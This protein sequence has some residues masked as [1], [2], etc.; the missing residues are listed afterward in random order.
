MKKFLSVIL[1]AIMLFTMAVPSFA[2]SEKIVNV[3]LVGYGSHLIDENGNTVW[4]AKSFLPAMEEMLDDLLKDLAKGM[5]IGDFDPYAQRLYDIIAPA[6]ED[7]KLDNNGE[8][9][10]ANGNEY[11]AYAHHIESGFRFKNPSDVIYHTNVKFSG[12]IYYFDY[13]WRLSPEYNGKLLEKHILNVKK[14]TGATKVNLIGRCLGGNIISALLQNASDKY[15]SDNINKVVMYIPSTMGVE[16]LTALMSGKIVLDPDAID[17]FVKYSMMENDVIGDALDPQLAETLSMIVEFVNEAYILGIGTE[18]IEGIVE[19]VK[20]SALARIMR[21]TYG[22]FPSFWSM[23]D[24]AEVEGAIN[25]VYNT[26]ELKTQYA[27][28]I[29]KIRSYNE[30]VQDNAFDRMKALSEAGL[31]ISVVSKYNYANFPLS[32]DAKK[33]SDGTAST[34]K[35]SFGATTSN[36]GETLTKKYINSLSEENLKYLSPDKM[37][38]ASTALFPQKTWF[39][40][41]L[42]HGDFPQG[43]DNFINEILVYNGEM[44]IDTY[45]AYPQYLDYDYET[46]SLSPVTG[47]DDGDIIPTG[48]EK[49]IPAFIKFF[50]FMFNLIKKLL[51]GELQLGGMLG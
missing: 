9:T 8:C 4:P 27:G 36:F 32:A 13:D 14:A 44:T 19:A 41:N 47:L 40:K 10:D 25:L 6:Y 15:I 49:R 5:L 16:F 12:G 48:N 37:I 17:N 3:Y 20:E 50:T 46:D 42:E 26:K 2:A 11:H 23:V 24:P 1:A 30:N 43:V 34:S 35:T 33:Q 21:D 22:S 45:E 51:S 29:E 18:V 39:M 31:D 7:V 28:M 38:D